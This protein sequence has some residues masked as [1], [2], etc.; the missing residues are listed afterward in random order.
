[1]RMRPWI[2]GV[3]LTTFLVGPALAGT[4]GGN[5]VVATYFVKLRQLAAR[6]ASTEAVDRAW[7][8]AYIAGVADTISSNRPLQEDQQGARC[9]RGKIVA[10]SQVRS[11]VMKA[12]DL[13]QEDK[14]SPMLDAAA[15]NSVVAGVIVYLCK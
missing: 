5:E 11:A 10:L 2:F 3:V 6:C 8:D 9:M 14:S 15:I 1:M 13:I 4:S 7:C 12:I